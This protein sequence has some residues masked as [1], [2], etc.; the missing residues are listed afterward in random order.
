[1]EEA[2]TPASGRLSPGHSDLHSDFHE[3]EADEGAGNEAEAEEGIDD[4]DEIIEEDME[5]VED[6]MD[7]MEVRPPR[8][9]PVQPHFSMDGG[10]EPCILF[11]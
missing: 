5:G 1:M 9:T 7:E 11:C 6:E 3:D 2:E 4:D 8:W 10:N